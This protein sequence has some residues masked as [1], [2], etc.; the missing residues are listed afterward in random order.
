MP[1]QIQPISSQWIS[2]LNEENQYNMLL[3]AMKLN[4]VIQAINMLGAGGDNAKGN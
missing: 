3:L 1:N 4:E 2:K